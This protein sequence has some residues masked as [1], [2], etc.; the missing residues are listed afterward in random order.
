MKVVNLIACF[1][2]IANYSFG[3]QEIKINELKQH[4]GDSVKV[5]TKVFSA[6]Y[7]EDA[8]GSPTFL[9]AGGKYPNSP[10]TI[11]IRGDERQNFDNAPEKFYPGKAV[12]VTGKIEL[13]KDKPQIVVTSKSQIVE[14]IMDHIDSKEPQ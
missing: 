12:C 1:F 5:C 10:L 8:K 4:V 3:Q 2:I 13:Y 14:Q 6:R 9:N 7:L 11:V